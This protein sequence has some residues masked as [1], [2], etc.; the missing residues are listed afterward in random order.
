MTNQSEQFK[1]ASGPAE[2][3]RSIKEIIR[4]LSRPVNPKRLK[5]RTQGG[6]TLD[7]LPWYE[8][9]RYLGSAHLPQR[10]CHEAGLTARLLLLLSP[11]HLFSC[12]Y[13]LKPYNNCA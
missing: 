3:P 5:Q 9:V 1:E 6:R 10:H 7:Y 12:R 2:G 11:S 4:D 8:A 13:H